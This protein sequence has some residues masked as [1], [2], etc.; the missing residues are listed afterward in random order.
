MGNPSQGPLINGKH[1]RFCQ[2]VTEGLTPAEAFKAIR[3]IHLKGSKI[4]TGIGASSAKQ[5]MQHALIKARIETLQH[6]AAR[7]AELTYDGIISEVQEEARLA[8]MAGQHSA[9]MK[10]LEMLGAELHQGMFT[11]RVEVKHQHEFDGMSEQQLREFIAS[12]MREVGLDPA[13][14][15]EGKAEEI[16]GPE[17][18][19]CS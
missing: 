16:A 8:R 1:E 4:I 19:A 5:L 12:Q 7:R 11:K 15:I 17:E 13:K 14:L 18:P 3:A 6:K 9:A 2:L 10:G